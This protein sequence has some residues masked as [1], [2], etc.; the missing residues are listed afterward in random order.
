MKNI[1]DLIVELRGGIPESC[2]FCDQVFTESRQ[3]VPEEAGEWA[4]TECLTRWEKEEQGGT[5]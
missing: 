3:P 1:L 5:T 2:D 4:C